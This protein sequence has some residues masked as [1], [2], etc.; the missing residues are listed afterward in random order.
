MVVV[1]FLRRG[2]L[3]KNIR[4]IA[5]IHI[6][7][8]KRNAGEVI[9]IHGRAKENISRYLKSIPK[10]IGRK[11]RTRVLVLINYYSFG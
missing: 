10:T 11:E 5:R 7:A 3:K 9:R 8:S 1:I 4:G 2:I 6:N